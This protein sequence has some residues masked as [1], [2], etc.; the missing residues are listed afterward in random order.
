[1]ETQLAE[2]LLS[3]LVVLLPQ[4][5]TV[6]EHDKRMQ[7]KLELI[8]QLIHVLGNRGL[9]STDSHQLVHLLLTGQPATLLLF[10]PCLRLY[11]LIH[12]NLWNAC[13]DSLQIPQITLALMFLNHA[14]HAQMCRPGDATQAYRSVFVSDLP[15]A[16]HCSG[17]YFIA[18]DITPEVLMQSSCS[19]RRM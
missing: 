11:M 16:E 10:R 12:L 15:T 5:S 18:G 14:L 8:L 13:W 3:N 4:L 2:Q 6:D 9:A 7:G 17:G 1:M 19:Q